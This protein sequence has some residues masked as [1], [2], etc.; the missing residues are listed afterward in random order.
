MEIQELSGMVVMLVTLEIVEIMEME[1][2]GMQEIVQTGEGALV[3]V[4][5]MVE[6]E[7]VR[8]MH[9]KMELI[10]VMVE[11]VEILEGKLELV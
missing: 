11:L 4:P 8:E 7:V 1:I 10:L 2:Q 3:E 5:E 6:M 9:L